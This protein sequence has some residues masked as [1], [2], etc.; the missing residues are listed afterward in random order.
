[1][2][3]TAT[4]AVTEE[5]SRTT[6]PERSRRSIAASVATDAASAV[7]AAAD[8]AAA[9]L[10]RLTASGRTALEDTN[11]RI[12]S[13]SD[14]MVRLGTVLSFGF[15]AGL[16]V[17][18]APRILVGAALVPTAMLGLALVDRT[19]SGRPTGPAKG[20]GGL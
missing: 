6:A 3:T 1:M 2:T 9:R 11:R 19:T 14:E 12:D 7:K 20:A 5:T 4:R 13:S 16:L 15:A 18:G 8:D 10:P 17:G